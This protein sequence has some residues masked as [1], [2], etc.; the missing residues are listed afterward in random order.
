MRSFALSIAIVSLLGLAAPPN[1]HAQARTS[2]N[3]TLL[4]A[5]SPFEDLTEAAMEK[6]AAGIA[7]AL[8]AVDAKA[9]AVRKA[10]PA[11]AAGTYDGLLA[12]IHRA[13]EAGEHH[14]IAMSAVDAFRLLLDNLEPKGLVVPREVLLLDSVGFRLHVLEAAPEADWE[15]IGKSVAEGAAWWAA[16]RPKVARVALRD[17]MD[18]AIRGLQEGEK[19]KNLP[20]LHFAAQVDLDLVDLLEGYFER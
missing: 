6:D 9:A 16:T 19:T 8:R 20:L 17:A 13:V 10:L 11:A 7:T 18:T 5:T 3:T 2:K 4:G 15:A 12:A 1:L 14:A